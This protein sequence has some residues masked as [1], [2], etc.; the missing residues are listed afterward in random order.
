MLAHG[1]GARWPMQV[2]LA[3]VIALAA[4]CD[5]RP[6]TSPDPRRVV[7]EGRWSGTLV[8]R[9]AGT[10]QLVVVA[11]GVEQSAYGTFT[12]SFA[13]PSTDV[14]G[15]IIGRT[16]DAPT[17]AMT[18]NIEAAGRDCPGAPGLFYQARLALSGSRMVGT[19][20]PTFGCA[21][22]TGGTI[23]LTRR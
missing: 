8:D 2:G 13:D 6:P 4:A 15:L 1:L 3:A 11:S 16:Q 10:G 12:V 23:E 5:E 22:L 20:E 18:L 14:R 21:L 19:Y 7:I 9:T 17:I